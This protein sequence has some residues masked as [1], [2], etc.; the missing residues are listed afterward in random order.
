MSNN[1]DK[2]VEVQRRIIQQQERI[3]SALIEHS[4]IIIEA[5][6]IRGSL[7]PEQEEIVKSIHFA[8]IQLVALNDQLQAAR[9]D[10]EAVTKEPNY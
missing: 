4:K 2:I 7:T 5:L 1:I 3:I 10:L 8:P 9:T 6:R